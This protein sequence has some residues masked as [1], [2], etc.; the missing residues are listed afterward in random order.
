MNLHSLHQG[1]HNT[2]TVHTCPASCKAFD[3]QLHIAW[4]GLPPHELL[5]DED[6]VVADAVEDGIVDVDVVVE[7]QIVV[8]AAADFEIHCHH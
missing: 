6:S 2:Y 8:A 7:D 1:K 4:N 5:S 3:D